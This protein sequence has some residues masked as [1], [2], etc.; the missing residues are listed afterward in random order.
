[1]NRRTFTE[2]A[3]KSAQP[4]CRRLAQVHRGRSGNTALTSSK[5]C[6]DS[7][8]NR[9]M[10]DVRRAMLVPDVIRPPDDLLKNLALFWDEILVIDYIG[11]LGRT[12][13]AESEFRGAGPTPA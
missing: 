13:G 10:P 5:E 7:G 2:P 11:G 4:V 9:V 8:D 3:R 6:A 1:M 12:N